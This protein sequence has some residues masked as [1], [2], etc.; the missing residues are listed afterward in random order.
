MKLS[1]RS[2]CLRSSV[3]LLSSLF[4]QMG[5]M[6]S[7]AQTLTWD[8]TPGTAGVQNGSGT[9]NTTTANWLDS[10]NANTL[11][12]NSGLEIAQFGSTSPVNPSV[13]TLAG[14]MKLKGMNFL[15][16]T[17]SS[18]P[19]S[20][21]QY[22]F[23]S[24][25]VGTVLDFGSD[26]LIQ[27]AD[28]SSGG[29]QFVGLGGNLVLKSNN[30]TIQ[31]I[32]GTVPQFINLSMA[33]NPDLTG[34]LTVGS[35]I[36]AGI[37]ALGTISN[38]SGITVKNN[39]TL[40]LG[41][42]G[43]Y[44]M[45]I[46]A[47]G[48]ASAY[49]AIRLTGSNIT[50]SGGI[51]LTADTGLLM[52]SANTGALISA[53]ITDGGLGYG[54]H[55]FTLTKS[56]GTVTLS[57]ANTYGGDT[58]LGRAASS[59]HSG[60]ITVLDFAATTAPQNDV[61]YNG[62]TNPGSLNL[63]GSVIGT[64]VLTLN[65][66]AATVNSQRL[67]NI[68]VQGTRSSIDLISG[69]GGEMNLSFNTINR[70]TT[71]M[72]AVTGPAQGSITTTGMADGF[73]GAWATYKAGSGLGS[74]AQVSG[75]KIAN[76]SGITPY[77]TGV[78][79]ASD[80][81]THLALGSD[82]MGS[83]TP[84]G[85]TSNLATVSMTDTKVDRTILTGTGNTLRL[86]A[87]G[88]VQITSDAKSLTIGQ[89]GV[90]SFLSAGG[91]SAGTGQLFLTN[92]STISLLTVHSGISNNAG[93]GAVALL[94]N[95]A[96][97]S[98]TMMTGTSTHTGGT[99]IASGALELRNAAA[100]GTTGT[101]N[102]L[103]G[104]SL[105]FSNNLTFTR[106]VTLS[107]LGT[108]LAVEGGLRN[109]S[110]NTAMTGLV[111]LIGNS[112][113]ISDAGTL[114]L[115]GATA[116]TNVATGTF[117]LTMGGRSNID[118]NGRLNIG[119]GILTKTGNGTLTLAGDNNFTGTI[120]I[121]GGVIRPTHA[122]ALGVS[123]TTFGSTTISA[124]AALEMTGNLTLAAEPITLSSLG[125][126]NNGGIRNVSGN[127]TLTS[128]ITLGA[129][130]VRV[131]SESGKLTFDTAS[132]ATFLQNTTSARTLVLSGAGDMDV[133]D[134]ISR[135]STGALTITKEGNGTVMLATSAGN[136]LTTLN[137]GKLH[138]DFSATS[139]PVTNILHNGIAAP[140]DLTLNSGILQI[141]GKSG[142]SNSQAFG[143][144]VSSG[145][146]NNGGN[147]YL[148]VVQNGAARVDL[149]FGPISR[150]VGGL[151][152]V[153]RPTTG[154][155]TTT[156]GVD[157]A[158]LT[159][160][161]GTPFMW[162]L[163]PTSGDEW[164]GTAAISGGVRQI[165]PLSSLSSGGYTASTATAL[166]GNADVAN[167]VGTTTLSAA[168]TTVTSLRF[169][170][171]QETN[172]TQDV[173]GRTL[174]ISGILVS[175]TAGNFAQTISVSNLRTP[176]VGAHNDLPI[177]QNNTAAPL[178][179]T[180][181]IANFSSSFAT[182]LVKSG[183]GTLILKGANGYS[184]NTR[185]YE[186]SLHLQAGS[187]SG[188]T[189]FLLGSGEKSGKVILGVDATPFNATVDWLQTYGSGTDNRIVGGASVI[190]LLTVDH[191]TTGNNFRTGFLGGPGVNENKLALSV[192]DTNTNTTTGVTSVM[193]LPLGGANTYSGQTQIRNGSVEVSVLA[194][195]GMASSLGTGSS[196]E[197]IEMGSGGG[198]T[199][200]HI[201]AGIRNVGS[202]DSVTDRPVQIANSVTAV[203][204]IAAM[205]ENNGTGVMQ[206]T[207]PFTSTGTNL[208]A[209]RK[210]V[211][212][213]TNTGANQ[214]VSMGNNG[215]VGTTVQKTGI[216]TW[217]ITGASTHSGGT[218]VDAGT[219]LV[220]NAIGSGT[221]TGS[222]TVAAGATL[223]GSGR[224]VP[225]LDQNVTLTGAK[226]QVGADL[227]GMT[228]TLASTLT[229]HTTGAGL[230]TLQ[231]DS[232]LM[233][234]LFTGAG[235]G[236]STALASAADMAILSGRVALS[237]TT[238]K[239]SNP[240]N[241]TAWSV[242][243]Q[244]RLFDWTG[245]A[246]PVSGGF[247]SYDLPSL[248]DGLLWDTSAIFTTGVLSI[249]VVP[250]PS[251]AIFMIFG[252]SLLLIRR[253]RLV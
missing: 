101:I 10:S 4:L 182:A 202:A 189:E 163:N 88:G 65:G 176:D 107:G 143:P 226:L 214:I 122:N 174:V 87:I 7:L 241:M 213:G 199:I 115:S 100:L 144:L 84:A 237:G 130:T 75:S 61:L 188:S 27:M 133:L 111:T 154:N 79:P 86:G 110:G 30:L 59:G 184:G 45:P 51:T 178:I 99:I 24:A 125:I 152:G 63:I 235:L 49:A 12:T 245:L 142:A 43:N 159:S 129:T 135:T 190:S 165:V 117:N 232:V 18:T 80:A 73:I 222:V 38:V 40:T 23:T 231:A 217:T 192:N 141:T 124:N 19:V 96:A 82:S 161:L 106:G 118:V 3:C 113:I 183:P 180:S 116:A 20:G 13:V 212:S 57:A 26:G 228:P 47:A 249:V 78:A 31:K 168:T 218:L 67:N 29:S 204:A 132:G 158:I 89:P 36:Y 71:G 123:G 8:T 109:V 76:F 15:P 175:S 197:V 216:G 46:T 208:T 211:L 94:V 5:L 136:T 121:N 166:S 92:N 53:P 240:A 252:T 242:N 103:E 160:S 131:Q 220:T 48:Y 2:A 35:Y 150:T 14:N 77:V 147:T 253:R 219:L 251:R 81:A 145:S 198:T 55:R 90:S 233:L 172:I 64:T 60:G 179:I 187:I 207:A 97:G 95:G 52:H 201:L 83:V 156:G 1:S 247:S 44:T 42:A 140:G 223:G 210:L 62:L 126:N 114:T 56:D 108:S 93:G 28:Y 164:L 102:I 17:A 104:G 98:T 138:L 85:T 203:V 169:A 238:L 248:P 157:N 225:G 33:S 236:D 229:I 170:Q 41:G 227:P 11:W 9:W 206:F 146:T 22:T 186:G 185:V 191:P 128:L 68:S 153:T 215:S 162:S 149:S 239:V 246:E 224:I 134:P 32:S 151:V 148:T 194:N 193:L 243:D 181:A 66:K 205:L 139:S 209:S 34:T 91:A 39:G 16:L 221:G 127:N 50:L 155:M 112:S 37:A 195:K 196:N 244:W 70:T 173:A 69:T 200:P 137:A 25:T 177:I 230:L 6:S 105:R 54:F 120:S 58:T 74:W 21:T 171:P 167:G 119:T 234:D 250:E 72:L